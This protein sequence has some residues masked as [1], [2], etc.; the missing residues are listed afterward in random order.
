MELEYYLVS[1]L[2]EKLNINV[3]EIIH[4]G[5]RNELPIYIS[6]TKVRNLNKDEDAWLLANDFT[7]KQKKEHHTE[8]VVT[9][10]H[11]F[12]EFAQ[13]D[14]S[15]IKTLDLNNIYANE[16]SSTIYLWSD[17]PKHTKTKLALYKFDSERKI[18][19]QTSLNYST[20]LNINLDCL[21]ILKD[22]V[23][24]FFPPKKDN[25]N[26][27]SEQTRNRIFGTL[28]EII[29]DKNDNKIKTRLKEGQKITNELIQQTIL[30]K[31]G[32]EKGVS[33]TN[34]NAL[35]ALGK[36]ALGEIKPQDE[37]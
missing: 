11:T 10:S 12:P 30:E 9:G 5:I 27:I 7:L 8:V 20:S 29:T 25:K 21:Y 4:K 14:L 1:E 28:L 34:I 15:T 26:E 17:K 22:D 35:F 19:F 23:E 6:R 32:Q 33:K 24:S 36:K 3:K 18:N 37:Q 13:L 2:A 31:Y 16:I